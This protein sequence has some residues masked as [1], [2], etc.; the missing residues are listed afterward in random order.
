MKKTKVL[1]VGN[2]PSVKGGI[3][4]V[5]NQ[6]LEHDWSAYNI[7]MCFIP[8]YSET[9]NIKKTLFF[10]VAYIK[11]LSV[12]LFQRPDV[13][14]MHMS[15]KGSF[16]RKY[17]LHRLCRC[18]KIRDVIH[19][20]GSEFEKWYLASDTAL[21][22]KIRRLLFESSVFVVLGEKWNQ[23]IKRIEPETNTVVVSN[24][25]CIP[26]EK[27]TWN[28]E[29]KQILFL[30]V[31]I[32]RKG[33]DDLL[34]AIAQLVQ[35]NRDVGMKFVIAGSG[36][37]ES[38]LRRKSKELGLDDFVSF[39]GWTQG[40]EKDKLF[41]KSHLLVLPSYNEGLPISIL[42]A[43]SYGM[44]VVAT[45]VGD[46]SSAVMEGKNGYLI[47]PGDING[48]ADRIEQVFASIS[49]YQAMSQESRKLAEQRFSDATYFAQMKACYQM[50]GENIE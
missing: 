43:I 34:Q 10:F 2:H 17:M 7:E 44:P 16:K 21:Q 29:D 28:G 26:R 35:S 27:I 42:E 3:T 46:I 25:V 19:L 14:H 47:Q 22:A 31:L 18:F 6:L 36:E 30:G 37:E 49:D 13:V 48:L 12:F 50:S 5:I 38:A 20:H 4:S 11:I 9:N 40:K 24:T 45:D 23:T 39:L 15:Y 33:V 1:M 41:L 32:R 8:T